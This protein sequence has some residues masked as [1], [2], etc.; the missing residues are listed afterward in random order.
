MLNNLK[1]LSPLPMPTREIN[2]M[3]EVEKY[4]RLMRENQHTVFVF[5]SNLSGRHGK[6]AALTAKLIFKAEQGVG[7][8]P[9]GRCYAIPTK[10][11]ELE[12]LPLEHIALYVTEFKKHALDNTKQLFLV[13]RVGCGLAGYSDH[14]IAPLFEDASANVILPEGWDDIIIKAKRKRFNTALGA[15][16]K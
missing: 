12:V 6:G 10:G 11:H 14:Q 9:T 7:Q 1:P 2:E 15:L 5:G 16:V 8:G 3:D 13:T 4:N